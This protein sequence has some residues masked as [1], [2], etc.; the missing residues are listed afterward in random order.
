MQLLDAYFWRPRDSLAEF[1]FSNLSKASLH[2]PPMERLEFPSYM[3]K[4][5]V[6][7]I[8][9]GRGLRENL[10]SLRDGRLVDPVP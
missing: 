7:A 1:T 8:K 2:E 10:H 3:C 9:W 5:G 4:Q 6:E